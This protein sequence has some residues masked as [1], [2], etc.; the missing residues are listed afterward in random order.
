ML[1]RAMVTAAGFL[2]VGL[3]ASLVAQSASPWQWHPVPGANSVAVGLL[4]RHGYDDDRA[5]ECGAARVLAECRLRR[6]RAMVPGVRASGLQ[7]VGDATVVFVLVDAAMAESAVRFVQV[8]LDDRLPIDDDTLAV[9]CA[10]VAL[11]ADD[12]EHLYPGLVLQGRA[13]QSLCLG[14]AGGRPVA[15]SALAVQALRPARVRE[16]LQSPVAVCG[17]ALGAVSASLR[18]AL[19][20]VPLPSIVAAAATEGVRPGLPTRALP[21]LDT[22]HDRVN[23]PFVA[24][25]FAVPEGRDLSAFA[26]GVEVARLRAQRRFQVR[27]N[28]GPGRAPFVAWSWLQ[29]DPALVFCRRGVSPIKLLRGEKARA[30]ANAERAATRVELE[31][32]L[33][34][35]RERAP[36]DEEVAA[37]CSSLQFEL[38]LQPMSPAVL[39]ALVSN[40]GA[41]PG[42]LEVLLLAAHRG[43]DGSALAAVAPPAVREALQAVL[44]PALA[45]WC[46]LMPVPQSDLTWRA[47]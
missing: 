6:A 10:E 22:V 2:G 19:Q 40:G 20:A 16:L 33:T 23:A 31:A 41:L 5:D 3:F 39:A 27:A 43:I 45:C 29:G 36:T 30:D 12:A 26:V 15:G 38:A 17:A 34:D 13:R 1:K 35:L 7:V 11:A 37:A 8:L 18:E 24:A 9:A 47:R 42:R 21:P 25:A 46:S 4:W 28:E 14:R 32:L 44:Q